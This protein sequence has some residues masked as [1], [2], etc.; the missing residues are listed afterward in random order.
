MVVELWSQWWLVVWQLRPAC[1]RLHSFLW[2][3]ACVAG[4]TVRADLL[5]VVAHVVRN[6][7][8]GF[9]RSASSQFVRDRRRR[10]G[11]GL[12]VEDWEA[13]RVATPPDRSRL[14][15][16]ASDRGPKRH[17]GF[18]GGGG[19]VFALFALDGQ[20][21]TMR[22]R[23][24]RL[25]HR[26]PRR[27]PS[28][29]PRFPCPHR[30]LR[31]DLA[32]APRPLPRDP[33]SPLGPRLPSSPLSSPPTSPICCS[34]SSRRCAMRTPS[35]AKPL[36]VS[37]SAARCRCSTSTITTPPSDPLSRPPQLGG[38]RDTTPGAVGHSVAPVPTNPAGSP[39]A[40]LI[41]LP[42][43]SGTSPRTHQ[44]PGL[45]HR[46][47]PL[48]LLTSRQPSR[49][50]RRRLYART[51]LSPLAITREKTVSAST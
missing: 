46:P 16:V 43:A 35:T 41:L 36:P 29:A 7:R 39:D 26:P 48:P 5:V 22:K 21:G 4:M 27:A 33:S 51:P 17:L 30:I 44:S 20:G 50:P 23:P 49:L 28:R 8:R 32:H 24:L 1:S 40:S 38:R 47:P 9:C 11:E 13:R 19:A 25:N 6:P 45:P 31:D 37:F 15:K 10:M 42:N 34:P 18:L 12:G 14:D 3:A 2:F